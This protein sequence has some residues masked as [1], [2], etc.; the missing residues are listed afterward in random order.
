MDTKMI[1]MKKLMMAILPVLLLGTAKAQVSSEKVYP[2][3][4]EVVNAIRKPTFNNEGL[5]IWFHSN[6]AGLTDELTLPTP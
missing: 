1:R 4:T 2:S 3:N 6:K 5:C